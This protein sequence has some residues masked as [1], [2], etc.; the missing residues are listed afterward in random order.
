M[1]VQTRKFTCL[2]NLHCVDDPDNIKKRGVCVYY[3]KTLHVQFLQ[4]K[5]DQ[6]IVS[7]VTFKNK[8]KGHVTS[9]YR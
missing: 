4:T 1:P 9:W 8:K 3:K 5:F 7:D 2:Y 6:C